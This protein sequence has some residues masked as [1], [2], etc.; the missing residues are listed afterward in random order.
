MNYKGDVP[1]DFVT[2][3]EI[4][5]LVAQGLRGL[6]LVSFM[7]VLLGALLVTLCMCCQKRD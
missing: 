1:E 5:A 4:E 2:E 7:G 6:A 3:E